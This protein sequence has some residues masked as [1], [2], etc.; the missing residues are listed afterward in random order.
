RS[1]EPGAVLKAA[2]TPHG[3]ESKTEAYHRWSITPDEQITMEESTERVLELLHQAVG[4][5][6]ESDVP[7]GALLS[8]GIDS[9]LVSAAAAK[10]GSS[11]LRTFNIR[12]TGNRYDETPMA[13]EVSKHIGS[14]HET[15]DIVDSG[16]TWDNIT[17]LLRHC[18]QPFAD[19]SVFAVNAICRAMRRHVTVALSGDGGDEGFGGYNVFSQLGTFYEAGRLPRWLTRSALSGLT[20][21]GGFAPRVGRIARR[22]RSFPGADPVTVMETLHCWVHGEELERLCRPLEASPI[23]RH[24]ERQWE[25]S[26]PPGAPGVEELSALATEVRT[27]LFLP[28]DYLFKVDVASMREGL[29]V[30][31]PFLDEDLFAYALRLPHRLKADRRRSKKVLRTIASRVLPEAVATHPKHGFDMPVREWVDEQFKECLRE[32]IS[33]SC[34]PEYFDASVYQPWVDAFCNGKVIP[35]M[36]DQGLSQRVIMLLSAHLAL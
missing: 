29:E 21:A 32:S 22:L 13:V 20:A 8:G 31:V 16:G 5:Q 10:G 17:G 11:R 26:I 34:L 14:Q 9:S 19:T 23:R 2:L 28:N 1:L 27:R 15:V 12:F 35:G 25:H 6:L 18:G 30:R 4:S 36:S 33:A 24:F 3:L 7:L